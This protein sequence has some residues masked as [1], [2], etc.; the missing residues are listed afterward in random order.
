LHKLLENGRFV[1]LTRREYKTE[2]LTLA[3]CSQ[4]NFGAKTT[5]AAT[6]GFNFSITM[7]CSSRVLMGSNDG[8]VNIMDLP[9]ELASGV[10]VLLDKLKEL[11]PKPLFTPPIKPAGNG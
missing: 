9:I 6:E 8:A 4:M 3:F 11:V 7:G 5:L 10:S 1:L 2:R